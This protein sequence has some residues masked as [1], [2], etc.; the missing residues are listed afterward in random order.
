VENRATADR[1]TADL[2]KTVSNLLQTETAGAVRSRARGSDRE[3][4]AWIYPLRLGP[5]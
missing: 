1:I 3:Y 4:G 2:S 5:L